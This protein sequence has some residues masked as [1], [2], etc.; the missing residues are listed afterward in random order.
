ME[1]NVESARGN[2]GSNWGLKGTGVGQCEQKNQMGSF[3][4][5]GPSAEGAMSRA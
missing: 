2:D 3:N 4:L 5:D 1:Y